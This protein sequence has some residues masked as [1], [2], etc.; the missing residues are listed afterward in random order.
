MLQPGGE[1]FS[2]SL[3]FLEV[4]MENIIAALQGCH[5][6][7]E[8]IW[9]ELLAHSNRAVKAENVTIPAD[10]LRNLIADCQLLSNLAGSFLQRL[11]REFWRYMAGEASDYTAGASVADDL[12]TQR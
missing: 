10:E 1:L 8:A 9:R 4:K 6:V 5:E 7:N 3:T 2:K 12:G 11:E